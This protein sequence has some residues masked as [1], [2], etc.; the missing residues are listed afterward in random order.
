ME[1]N[2]IVRRVWLFQI[3]VHKEMAP[4]GGTPCP[5]QLLVAKFAVLGV[6]FR[7]PFPHTPDIFTYK[8]CKH[9]LQPF[10]REGLWK[11][12]QGLELGVWA[13]LRWGTACQGFLAQVRKEGCGG[14][15]SNYAQHFL[16]ASTGLT[17]ACQWNGNLRKHT[18]NQIPSSRRSEY[19]LDNWGKRFEVGWR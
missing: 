9:F 3:T 8:T 4:W 14:R 13:C 16:T 18:R 12:Q 19:N 10:I 17:S 2:K 6:A 1:P 15:T 7:I 11:A 5:L